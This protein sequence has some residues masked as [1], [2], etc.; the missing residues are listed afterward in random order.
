MTAPRE[1]GQGLAVAAFVLGVCALI[2][3]M[4]AIGG[5]FGLVGLVLGV[6][7]LRRS[8]ANRPLAKWGIA[9]SVVGLVGSVLATAFYVWIFSSAG[10]RS[11]L[12]SAGSDARWEDWR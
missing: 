1:P 12:A 6:V 8:D 10:L 3:A 7:H 4:I 5:L 2:W 11:R 9:L